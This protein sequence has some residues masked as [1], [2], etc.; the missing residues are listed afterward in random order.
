[1]K[2]SL[3]KWDNLLLSW[4][5]WFED[6]TSIALISF[7]IVN[8]CLSDENCVFGIFLMMEDVRKEN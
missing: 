3:I 8:I 2:I 6:Y 4:W 5:N 7:K 1:M